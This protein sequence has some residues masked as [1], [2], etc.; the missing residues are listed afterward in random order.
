MTEGR[1]FSFFVVMSLPSGRWAPEGGLNSSGLVS[2]G[3]EGPSLAGEGRA[4]TTEGRFFSFF[5]V[6]SLPSGRWAPEG[7]LNSSGLVSHGEEGPSLAG[8]GRAWTT[9]GRFFLF[10]VRPR[11]VTVGLQRAD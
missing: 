3:E 1:F 8:E 6:M 7:G 11:R 9:E 2:H 4:W 10:V 5:V